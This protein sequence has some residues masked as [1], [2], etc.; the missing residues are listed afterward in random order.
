MSALPTYFAFF[1]AGPKLPLPLRSLGA[2]AGGG[3]RF[4]WGSL[5]SSS[6]FPI[7]GAV[8]VGGPFGF[9]LFFVGELSSLSGGPRGRG[10]LGD[11]S[12]GG[13]GGVLELELLLELLSDPESATGP[14]AGSAFF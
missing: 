7:L 14:D 10:V 9:G 13:A 3:P 5:G 2:E 8:V 1:L 11:F 6:I 4:F 12:R